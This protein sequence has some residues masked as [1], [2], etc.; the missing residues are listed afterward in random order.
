MGAGHHHGHDHDHGPAD[1]NRAFLMGIVLNTLFVAVE[2]GYGF[3]ANSMALLADAGHNLGDVLGLVV[4]WIG[5]R[6][7]QRRASPRFTYGLKKSS[8]L[9]A[10]IN[11]LLLL[12]AVGGI[13]AE[14]IRR[15]FN[16]E[17]SDGNLVMAV[18]AVGIVINAATALLFARGRKG[19]INIRGA[20]LHMMADAAVSAG[21]VAAGALILW[22]GARWID[23]ATSLVVAAIILW[24]TWGLLAE[25]TSMTLAGTPKGIDPGAVRE[26]LEQLP[27]VTGTHHLHIWALSTTETAM[28]V[29]LVVD[30]NVDRDR[31]LV[32]ARDAVHDRFGIAHSTVQVERS[33][34]HGDDCGNC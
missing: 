24:G 18:A 27:G 3:A 33:A 17:S 9:A 5:A 21:V 1:F 8:I 13:G 19:D 14:A 6:L 16:P 2:A 23:P 28:T 22:T 30:D 15:L 26:A 10:L 32:E 34:G 29:H 4:A 25:S 12:I 31:V 7:V 11:A 20:Y